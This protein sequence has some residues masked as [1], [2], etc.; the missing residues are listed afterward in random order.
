MEIYLN[1]WSRSSGPTYL[2][3]GNIDSGVFESPMKE[4]FLSDKIGIKRLGDERI[5]LGIGPKNLN[6]HGNYL[7][8]LQI[9][10]SEI[11][12]LAIQAFEKTPSEELLRAALSTYKAMK[13]AGDGL[14]KAQLEAKRAQLELKQ[15][16]TAHDLTKLELKLA[17]QS[18]ANEN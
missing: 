4:R 9:Y 8:A 6:L 16:K 13:N 5:V 12:S 7:I 10:K 11:L 2:M 15:E 3:N 14:A 1:G 17:R 18:R